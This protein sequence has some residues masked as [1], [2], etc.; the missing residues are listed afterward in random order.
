MKRKDL[1]IG[2]VLAYQP[3]KFGAIE[4]AVVM[5]TEPV[6]EQHTHGGN[7]EAVVP[8]SA[9]NNAHVALLYDRSEFKNGHWITA[10]ERAVPLSALRGDWYEVTE[11]Q[12]VEE[13]T[14]QEFE[15]R[16]A[17]RAESD[18][19]LADAVVVELSKIGVEAH[20]GPKFR[21]VMEIDDAVL[22]ANWIEDAQAR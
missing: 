7:R 21:I 13:N 9:G 15:A 6:R 12:A 5:G 4:A 8:C 11:A 14:R 20:V 1:V 19:L 10:R 18:E 16:L 22:L 17:A 2:Q 3:S